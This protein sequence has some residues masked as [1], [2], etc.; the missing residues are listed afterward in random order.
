MTRKLLCALM[1]MCATT[2]HAEGLW[3][4][5]VSESTP[6]EVLSTT[7][8]TSTFSG[9]SAMT[10]FRSN[11][12]AIVAYINLTMASGGTNAV[13][14]PGGYSDGVTGADYYIN[15]N[16]AITV[17][18]NGLHLMRWAREDFGSD[19]SIKLFYRG[20]GVTTQSTVWI[21]YKSEVARKSQ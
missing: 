11:N 9:T 19:S 4:G 14:A 21:R 13:F 5:S 1:L 12:S 10:P 6:T 16:K 3:Y 15:T 20:E 18:T 2:L 7:T 17:T 8:L